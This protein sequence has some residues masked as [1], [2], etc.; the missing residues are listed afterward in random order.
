MSDDIRV[1]FVCGH[2][3]TVQPDA[4]LE[5]VQ[6]ECGERR[7]RNVVAPKPRIRSTEC[8]AQSPLRVES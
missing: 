1:R 7:V 5:T 3:V 8:D 2:R 4:Q 6:C